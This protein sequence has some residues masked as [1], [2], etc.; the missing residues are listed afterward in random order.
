MLLAQLNVVTDAA[1]RSE[2]AEDV[3]ARALGRCVPLL[4]RDDVPEHVRSLTS[5]KV[6][7]VEQDILARLHRRAGAGAKSARLHENRRARLDDPA[8][9]R[10]SGPG[11]RR[12]APRRRGCR[13]GREDHHPRHHPTHCWRAAGIG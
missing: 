3:T 8:S 2:L 9:G 13:R 7:E 6:L 11:R 1:V 5:P 12:H 4:A 10:G